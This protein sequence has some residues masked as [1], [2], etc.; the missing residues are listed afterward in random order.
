M[1]H[2][3]EVKMNVDQFLAWYETQADGRFELVNGEVVPMSPERSRHNLTKLHVVNALIDAIEA[4][5]ADCTA[6]TD[7]MG[8]RCNDGA[9]YEPD[10]SIQIGRPMD[11]DA[12]EMT[13][14]VVVVE[15]LSPSS[16]KSDATTKL[17]G[18][19]SVASIAHYLVIDSLHKTVVHHRRISA[20]ECET[21]IVT[22]G[23]IDLDPP[24][25]K[26]SVAA[27][28]GKF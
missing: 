1:N 15:V 23:S 13:A 11:G 7:G 10:A 25:I 4:S 6:Y 14:P 2:R 5:G 18:Y 19:L 22:S 26:V 9:L 17:I 20:S 21:S 24:G 3:S 12:V 16:S 8:V 27:L 28:F